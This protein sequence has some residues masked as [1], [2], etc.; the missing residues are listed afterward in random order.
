MSANQMAKIHTPAAKVISLEWEERTDGKWGDVSYWADH[1][2]G[3]YAVERDYFSVKSWELIAGGCVIGNF[4]SVEAAQ[5]A[6][7]GNF[8][9][10]VRS[11]LL[12]GSYDPTT[13]PYDE[14]L[15]HVDADA[16][17][18]R[19][20][21]EIERRVSSERLQEIEIL[22]SALADTL[23]ELSACV[24]QLTAKGLKMRDGGSVSRAQI[25]AR[26][27]LARSTLSSQE[28]P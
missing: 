12:S 19:G 4:D 15:R 23:C 24:N 22:R 17:L 26:K 9:D 7:Q 21:L 16:E 5:I 8:E 27:A 2:F 25:A 18:L 1:Q 14:P 13:Q 11:C 10:R 20:M 28:S 6:A 3:C